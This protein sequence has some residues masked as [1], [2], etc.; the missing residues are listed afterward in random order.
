MSVKINKLINIP[1]Y[2]VLPYEHHLSDEECQFIGDG[3][4][5]S[6]LPDAK[7]REGRIS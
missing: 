2:Q 3:M 4:D 5:A 7:N 1:S 6:L